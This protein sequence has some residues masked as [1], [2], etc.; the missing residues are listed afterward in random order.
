VPDVIAACDVTPFLCEKRMV[1]ARGVLSE[2]NR[3]RPR[4]RSARGRA[5]SPTSPGTEGEGDGPIGQLAAYVQHLPQPTHLVLVEEDAALLEPIRAAQPDAVTRDFVRLRDDALPGWIMK[6]ASTHHGRISARG[7]R[8]LAELIG[9]DLRALDS[10]LAKLATYVESDQTIEAEDVRQLVAGAAPAI[11]TFHDALAE[12]RP[13][14]AL[15]AARGLLGK[16]T[17]PVEL[18]TQISGLVR[19]LLIVKELT[20]QRRSLQRDAPAFGL[21]S[22]TYALEKLQRQAAPL[23]VRELEDA[24]VLM[25]DTDIAVKRGR[26]DPE[27]AVELAVSQL[28]GITTPQGEAT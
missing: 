20:A 23:S 27:L 3:R 1:I 13:A 19:R 24:Y 11:F 28:V 7:A 14:A 15:A 22:N 2:A 5:T 6:R 9:S 26:L 21:S 17:D 12:R 25:R 8:E 4:R 18:L 16:G 10:D